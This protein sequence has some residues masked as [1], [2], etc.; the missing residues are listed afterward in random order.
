[1]TNAR[2]PAG[3]GGDLQ[4]GRRDALLAGLGTGVGAGLG[5]VGPHAALAYDGS[6]SRGIV[7]AG[8]AVSQT[9]TLQQAVNDAAANGEPLFLPAGTYKTGT[10]TL[11]AGTH[12]HGV[13]GRTILKSDGVPILVMED[14]DNV[15]LSGLVLDGGGAPLGDDGA[16]M[17]ATGATGLDVSACRFLNSGGGG[18]TLR[19]TSGRVS[20]CTFGN[21]TSA[22]L[23]S[24]DAAGLE[25]SSNH[26]HDCGDNGILVWRSEKGDDGTLVTDNRI[27]RIAAKSGGSGQNGNGVN[28]FRAGSVLVTQNRISDCAY[29]AIRS[30]AGSNCQMVANSCSRLG[31]V[32]LYAEFGFEGALIANN[33]VDTAAT[34]ISVT[35]FNEGGRLAVVQG[36]IVRNLFFR[37]TG[38]ARGSGIAVEADTTVTANVVE[39]APAYGIIVGWGEY[40][41]DVTVTANV[42]RKSHIGIGVA[43]SAGAGAALITDNL[44][45]G[46]Q[47][48]A[49]RAMKGPTPVGPD[50]ALESAESYPNLAVYSNVVR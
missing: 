35:N 24:E 17:T 13:P 49:I 45:D 43:A 14:A 47:D 48:G 18:V 28:V 15:R 5:M 46:A 8:G 6:S 21:I 29:S 19:K 4:I 9:A 39:G 23:F 22:A 42:V 44:I 10:L 41:R 36:N 50:L 7:P 40:M 27:E 31:E 30:N 1:M 25:I 32:A 33:I 11:P 38:E 20:N 26:I 3:P 34:G 12:V 37:K 16:L 2:K